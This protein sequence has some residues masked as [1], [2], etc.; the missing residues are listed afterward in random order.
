MPGG[1]GDFEKEPDNPDNIMREVSTENGHP[2]LVHPLDA[3]VLG[4][5]PKLARPVGGTIGPEQLHRG[6]VKS[7]SIC[8][9]YALQEQSKFS[10]GVAGNAENLSQLI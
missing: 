7:A 10:R 2:L 1:L 6:F 9:M 3:T 8:W 4:H 5:D